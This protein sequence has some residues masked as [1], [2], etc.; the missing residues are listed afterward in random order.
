M[1]RTRWAM[2]VSMLVVLFGCAAG[3]RTS[4]KDSFEKARIHYEQGVFLSQERQYKG[5]LSA[6][7]KAV[8]LYPDYGDAYF[9]MG[10]VY[11]ELDRDDEAIEAYQKA[12]AIDPRDVTARNNLGNLYIRQ[13]QLSAAIEMLE[14]AV[15]ID[16]T[17][18]V[19]RSNLALAYYLAKMYHRAR[20]ELNELKGLGITPDPD[21]MESVEAALSSGGTAGDG[22]D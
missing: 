12:I 21:L 10:I 22:G 18:G 16:P 7:K 13:G 9:N 15:R 5:A 11:Y 20:D 2:I 19:A 8:S 3:T 14:Q 6:F 17:Y 4:S 1:N